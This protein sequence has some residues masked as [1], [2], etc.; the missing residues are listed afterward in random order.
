MVTFIYT[1]RERH[2]VPSEEA[3]LVRHARWFAIKARRGMRFRVHHVYDVLQ[4]RLDGNTWVA[5]CPGC[6][7]GIA[8]EPEWSVACCFG[9]GAV[10]RNFDMPDRAARAQIEATLLARPQWQTRAW[11]PGETV[12]DLERE[13]AEHG[14]PPRK[15]QP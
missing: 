13:N 8:I 14:L 3:L 15:E 7:A 6:S 9:C 2:G 11:L 1:A 4:V 5:D 12:A 10:Y